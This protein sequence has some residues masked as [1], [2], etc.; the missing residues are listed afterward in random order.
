MEQ[1]PPSAD[2]VERLVRVY[3]YN[4]PQGGNVSTF[5]QRGQQVQNQ[6]NAARDINIGTI[7]NQP[8]FVQEL[9]KLKAE[10][11]R[12]GEA[13][14]LSKDAVIDAEYEITKAVHEA[15]KPEPKKATILERLD[16]TKTLVQGATAL[17]TAV[18]KLADIVKD[19]PFLG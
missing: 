5:D 19:L 15:E 8:D 13:Q 16:R 1:G 6:N 17:T 7:Q 2:Q 4:N 9:Q 18:V 11:A 10:V 14:L 12:A 3:I